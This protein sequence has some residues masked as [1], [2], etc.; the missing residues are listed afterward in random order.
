MKTMTSIGALFLATACVTVAPVA[1]PPGT[2]SCNA[3]AAQRLVGQTATA[4]LGAE[5]LRLTG[6]STIRWIP[7]GTAVT[8]DYR[9]DRLNIETDA[10]NRVT[11]IRCG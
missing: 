8:M 9:P 1:P 3:A 4:R 11:A 7:P 5:A 6:A 10:N 2:A